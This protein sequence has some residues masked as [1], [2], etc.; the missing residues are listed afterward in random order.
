LIRENSRKICR[1]GFTPFFG[2][3]SVP[4]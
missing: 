1:L 4:A 3:A 2:I